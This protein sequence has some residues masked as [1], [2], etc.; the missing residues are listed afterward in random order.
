MISTHIHG[1]AKKAKATQAKRTEKARL[2]S[3][4]DTSAKL[5]KR[6]AAYLQKHPR[7]YYWVRDEA[8]VAPLHQDVE[9][10]HDDPEFVAFFTGNASLDQPVWLYPG[11]DLAA[12]RPYSRPVVIGPVVTPITAKDHK[13]VRRLDEHLMRACGRAAPG[14]PQTRVHAFGRVAT[15]LGTQEAVKAALKAAG[16]EVM[17]HAC[18][19]VSHWL[20]LVGIQCWQAGETAPPGRRCLTA[21]CPG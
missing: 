17:S 5:S 18:T 13:T 19:V 11:D 9:G 8:F 2:E 14:A 20:R 16:F 3:G 15:C 7:G 4:V 21:R 1:A 10:F 12:G 6:L